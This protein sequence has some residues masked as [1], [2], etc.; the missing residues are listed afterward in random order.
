MKSFCKACA[1]IVA[2]LLVLVSV[3][4]CTST[5]KV[6]TTT[7]TKDATMMEESKAPAM[8]EEKKD[9][10]MMENKDAAVTTATDTMMKVETT[11]ESK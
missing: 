1:A 6:E 5:P 8:M 10:A 7:E 4:A 2:C 11:T 3:T 9:G